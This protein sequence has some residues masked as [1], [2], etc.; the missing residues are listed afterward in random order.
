M[1]ETGEEREFESVR[2]KRLAK[3]IIWNWFGYFENDKAQKTT[4][5]K[6]CRRT[7]STNM[8]NTTNLL[9]HLK[10]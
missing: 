5:S 1:S 6:T 8:G 4:V 3:S 10:R 2:K 7:V 9:N